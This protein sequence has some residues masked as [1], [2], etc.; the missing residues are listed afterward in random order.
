MLSAGLRESGDTTEGALIA[1]FGAD[2][3][4]RQETPDDT[5]T[6]WVDATQVLEILRALKPDYPMLYDLFGIDERLREQRQGQPQADFTVV[7][8]LL[9]LEPV[10]ELRLQ[11]RHEAARRADGR[12]AGAQHTRPAPH[13]SGDR[14]FQPSRQM[15]RGRR[16]DRPRFAVMINAMPSPNA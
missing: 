15:A 8:H 5:P 16:R 11:R 13:A 10:A 7:Y 9:S 14:R 3:F 1:R 6:Y 4:V 12:R 2:S